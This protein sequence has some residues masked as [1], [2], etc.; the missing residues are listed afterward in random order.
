MAFPAH[1]RGLLSGRFG[2][3][4]DFSEE[5]LPPS[6]VVPRH[7]PHDSELITYVC[8]GTLAFEDSQGRCGFVEAGG[9]QRI[10]VGNRVHLNE[11]N[12]SQ[13]D[14]AHVF[15]IWIRPSEAELRPDRAH[16][17]FTRAERRAVLCP[18]ASSDGRK[19]SLRIHQDALVYSSFFDVGHHVV[20]PLS[21][22]RIAWLH[23]VYGEVAL[24]DCVLTSG[25]GAGYEAE[26][27]VS[28]TAQEATEILLVDLEESRGNS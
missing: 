14:W 18:V 8:E 20:H 11:R 5:R 10:T 21:E 26:R 28:F 3:L 25:D 1:I 23:L 7:A 22:H 15:R 27:G 4:E 24:G 19:G 12:P 16:K 6:S 17:R 2:N 9:F 13:T